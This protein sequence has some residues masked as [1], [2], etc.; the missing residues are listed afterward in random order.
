MKRT[1]PQIILG[2]LLIA[3]LE[4]WSQ[5]IP[6]YYRQY[7][8]LMAPPGVFQDGLLGFVNPAVLRLYGKEEA[9]FYWNT[10]GNDALSFNDW[11]F[12][13]GLH[14]LGFGIYR[15]HPWANITV[16][17]Y[18]LSLGFGASSSTRKTPTSPDRTPPT[19]SP[20]WSNGP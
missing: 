16:T 8:F 4:V 3:T 13:T 18:R 14:R 17:D 12:F 10:D 6:D 7:T 11:G 19:G 1:L 20:A 5:P 2:S 9:R 15:Q